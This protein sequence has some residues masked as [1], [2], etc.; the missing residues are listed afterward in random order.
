VVF[1]FVFCAFPQLKKAPEK[2]NNSIDRTFIASKA[3]NESEA[4]MSGS[5]DPYRGDIERDLLKPHHHQP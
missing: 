5:D 3:F 1:I 4:V 2:V